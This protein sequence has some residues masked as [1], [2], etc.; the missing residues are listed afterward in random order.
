MDQHWHIVAVVRALHGHGN[1]EKFLT[2]EIRAC[3]TEV[4]LQF[5]MRKVAIVLIGYCQFVAV[6]GASF[7]F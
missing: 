7:L 3:E 1:L 4:F 6:L 5:T 2:K